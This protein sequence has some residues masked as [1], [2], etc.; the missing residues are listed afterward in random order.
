MAT[1]VNGAS[2]TIGPRSLCATST[3][4]LW[5]ALLNSTTIQMWYSDDSG[6]TWTQ[7][8]SAQIAGVTA[9][10]QCALFIDADDHA[11]IA[12]VTTT[13]SAVEYRRMASIGTSTSWASADALTWTIIPT[14]AVAGIVVAKRR[15][16]T[17]PGEQWVVMTLADLVSILTGSREGVPF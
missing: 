9:G 7:N 5:Q 14:Y 17:A 8:T 6:A 10:T 4:R 16:T 1:D 15:G 12:Y 3:G 2:A 11:H 13:S